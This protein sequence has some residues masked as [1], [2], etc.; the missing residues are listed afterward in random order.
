MNT[1]GM[2][3]LEVVVVVIPGHQVRS[4]A[5]RLASTD[6]AALQHRHGLAYNAP[7]AVRTEA[8]RSL[9]HAAGSGAHLLFYEVGSFSQ[10]ITEAHG[11]GAPVSLAFA[12]IA[13]ANEA[14]TSLIGSSSDAMCGICICNRERG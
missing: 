10:D 2:A 8:S 1:T 9:S 14:R 4:G 6:H 7:Y 5:A 12:Q 3:N 11:G 13:H